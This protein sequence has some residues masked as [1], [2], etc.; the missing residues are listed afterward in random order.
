MYGVPRARAF[1]ELMKIIFI[2]LNILGF[3]TGLVFAMVG[4]FYFD[5]TFA[6]PEVMPVL[7]DSDWLLC[8]NSQLT[9][10]DYTQFA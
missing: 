6:T 8:E 10:Y 9:K 5:E 4:K 2:N 3:L 7:Y 1:F